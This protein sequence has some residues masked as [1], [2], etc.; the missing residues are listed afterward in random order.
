MAEP[1]ILFWD[2]VQKWHL[3]S[4]NPEYKYASTNPCAE[5]PLPNGGSCLLSSLNLSE[6]VLNPFSKHSTFDIDSFQT[7]VKEVVKYMD[8]LLEEGIEYLPLKEQRD[9]ARDYRQLGIGIMGMADMFIKLGIRYGSPESIRIIRIIM[10][11]MINVALQTSA[12][13]ASTRGTYRKYNDSVLKSPFLKHV[14]S[15]KTIDM[16]KKYGLRNAELLSIAPNG[17]ISTLLGVS[18]GVEPIFQISYTRK[19]ESLG[20][21]EDV[22]YQVYTPIVKEYMDRFNIKDESDLPEYFV[23]AHDLNYKERIEVQSVLQEYVD[24]A[25]SSTINL[26]EETS[27]ED[28]KEIY[29]HAWKKKLKGITIYRDNCMRVGV[30]TT[31]KKDKDDEEDKKEECT[32]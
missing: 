24:S 2:T 6:Y 21:G 27:V 14:A 12:F 30:L 13:L 20:D 5:K 9:T 31:S 25:I 1:G 23:T 22:Y 10:D 26:P 7:D 17:S 15:K 4:E 16:I 32:T 29:T 18:G 28:I 3:N 19:S 8:D 11:N